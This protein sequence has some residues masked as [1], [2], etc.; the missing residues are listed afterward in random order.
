M[1]ERRSQHAILSLETPDFK[2]PPGKKSVYLD[3]SS[4]CA[5]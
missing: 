4:S 3:F 5:P 1:R 2:Y